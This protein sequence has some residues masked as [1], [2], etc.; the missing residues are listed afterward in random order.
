MSLIF[1][2]SVLIVNKHCFQCKKMASSENLRFGE[3]VSNLQSVIDQIKGNILLSFGV[4]LCDVGNVTA[5]VYE[6]S[7]NRGYYWVY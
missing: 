5:C 6:L 1:Y 7:D 2:A 3:A 4:N